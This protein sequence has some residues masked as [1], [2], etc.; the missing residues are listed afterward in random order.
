[1]LTSVI[2]FDNWSSSIAIGLYTVPDTFVM[3]VCFSSLDNFN[4]VNVERVKIKFYAVMKS[5]L[6][7][8]SV[9]PGTKSVSWLCG[10]ISGSAEINLSI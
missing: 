9:L 2:L 6:S 3:S 8:M 4:N 10:A 1:M 7:G 5:Y